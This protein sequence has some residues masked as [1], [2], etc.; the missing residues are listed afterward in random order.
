MFKVGDAIRTTY[1]WSETG[2]IV[3]PRARYGE[4]VPGPGWHAVRFDS[5]GGRMC[6]HQDMMVLRNEG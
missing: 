1:Q 2:R 4:S 3:K 6:I 5:N